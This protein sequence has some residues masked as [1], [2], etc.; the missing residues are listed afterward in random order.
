[1]NAARGGHPHGQLL[2]FTYISY[3]VS[4]NQTIR[5]MEHP[6]N[7][8]LFSLFFFFYFNQPGTK[9]K[10]KIRS[11]EVCFHVTTEKYC[12]SC[13]LSALCDNNKKY[14]ANC[15][16]SGVLMR[17]LISSTLIHKFHFN[18]M[19]LW[20]CGGEH[21]KNTKTGESLRKF[22]LCGVCMLFQCMN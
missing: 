5:N 12:A 15:S 18:L 9:K 19:F 16:S 10:H 2:S 7:Y 17:W 8:F 14:I 20:D 13:S 11:L 21:Q 22:Y 1:M 4:S 6:S 3:A